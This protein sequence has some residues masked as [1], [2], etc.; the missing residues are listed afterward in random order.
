M[1]NCT[2]HAG[3]VMHASTPLL[4]GVWD[5]QENKQTKKQTNKHENK[6]MNK[7]ANKQ[8]KKNR[9]DSMLLI[10]QSFHCFC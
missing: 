6:R 8:N 4:P 2:G 5:V 10:F 3:V 9:L 7:Q 1:Q